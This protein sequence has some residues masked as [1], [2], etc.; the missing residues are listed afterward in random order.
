M[1]SAEVAEMIIAVQLALPR[2]SEE[3]VFTLEEFL[4]LQEVEKAKAEGKSYLYIL[5]RYLHSEELEGEPADEGK[6]I[7]VKLKAKI[8]PFNVGLVVV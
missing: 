5:N 8:D 7:L 3:Q 1:T 4:K 6:D 2:C